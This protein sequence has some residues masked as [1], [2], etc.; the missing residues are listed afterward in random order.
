MGGEQRVT[1]TIQRRTKTGYKSVPVPKV[2]TS[3][4][5]AYHGSKES[6]DSNSMA[7]EEALGLLSVLG[8]N[9]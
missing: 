7:D 9:D 5:S 6:I 2:Q 8:E 4:F 1:S 3:G